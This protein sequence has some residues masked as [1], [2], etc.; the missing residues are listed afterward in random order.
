MSDPREG[1][2]AERRA[3]GKRINPATAE[4]WFEYA[5][6]ADPYG[7]GLVCED[8]RGTVGREFFA[9]DPVERIPVL[10]EDLPPATAYALEGEL[11][12]ADAE[13]WRAIFDYLR[14][15]R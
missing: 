1:W 11:N 13:G 2:M 9:M 3:A 14:Y 10:F 6:T 15:T 7:D 5:D 12:R 4:V 8:E